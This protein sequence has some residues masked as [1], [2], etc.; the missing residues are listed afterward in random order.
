MPQ[1][2]AY[3][4][5]GELQPSVQALEQHRQLDPVT[6]ARNGTDGILGELYSGLGRLDL[7]ADAWLRQGIA[8][9]E[10][11]LAEESTQAQQ[12]SPYAYQK[13][14]RQESE[15]EALFRLGRSYLSLDQLERSAQALERSLQLVDVGPL[16][17]NCHRLLAD[18]YS[19]LGKSDS[20]VTRPV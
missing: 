8:Y 7:A 15:A 12:Q 2:L 6:A 9:Q 11:N 19:S 4:E 17:Q 13:L 16:A 10:L 14:G 5:L 1:G 18:I 20:L 3:R